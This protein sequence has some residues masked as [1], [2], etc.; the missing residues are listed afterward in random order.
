MS[1]RIIHCLFIII[2]FLISNLNSL[3]VENVKELNKDSSS[4]TIEWSVYNDDDS[5]VLLIPTTTN[6]DGANTNNNNN[7]WIGFKIKYFTDKLKYTPVF[8]KNINLRKF[9]LDNLKSNT[10]YKIQVSAVNKLD[11]E[12]PASNLLNIKTH[13]AGNFFLLILFLS[14]IYSFG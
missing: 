2:T 12:G 9:R 3:R 13:E 5:S 6:S 11:F 10:D 14:P 8:L 7:E 1:I 4:I